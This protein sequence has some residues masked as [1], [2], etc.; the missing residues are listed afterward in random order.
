MTPD[1]EPGAPQAADEQDTRVDSSD[2]KAPYG[3][4]QGLNTHGGYVQRGPEREWYGQPVEGSSLGAGVAEA[5]AEARGSSN[6]G[7]EGSSN[8]G[9]ENTES[10]WATPFGA[11]PT[12][13]RAGSY[14]HVN[15]RP[16]DPRLLAQLSP[17]NL[18]AR[19]KKLGPRHEVIARLM[20]TGASDA[21]ISRVVGRYS[22][23]RL[24]TLRNS[25]RM[26]MRV[27]E[28]QESYFGKGIEG[29]FKKIGLK[30]LDK[31]EAILDNPST[32]GELQFKV[33]KD[34]MDRAYGKAKETVKVESNTVV[35]LFA[36]LDKLKGS[37][38]A[39]DLAIAA[40]LSAKTPG[41]PPHPIDAYV[42]SLV[43]EGQGI[44]QGAKDGDNV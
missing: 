28:I 44:G 11:P 22:Q 40:L 9:P 14:A 6:L 38:G 30:A 15:D 33:S 16:E 25:P 43:P 31:A 27:Q 42:D 29:R 32:S 13:A 7:L 35:D 12:L 2:Q 34:M 5:M 24:S 3:E 19:L 20:A 4:G 1:Q 37:G 36:A 10:P 23:T 8:L 26:I 18:K 21:E 39:Q 17:T 41:E